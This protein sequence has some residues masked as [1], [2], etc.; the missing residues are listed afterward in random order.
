MSENPGI[1]A[2]VG[3]WRGTSRLYLPERSPSVRQSDSLLNVSLKAKGQFVA[4]DYTWDF[5]GKAQ[6]GL[7]IL[8]CDTRS[9][10]AQAVW[11][12]SWH[13]RNTLMISNGEAS[14]DG[15]VSVMGYYKV[16]GHPDWGWR[17]E[18]TP[19]KD[20]LRLVMYNV[21]P[22]GDEEL[23]VKAEYAKVDDQ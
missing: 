23:A 14:E 9:N 7:I 2:C 8:G 22:E 6:E 1:A 15:S 13:S 18:I 10:A 3:K 12:D 5:E 19:S 16:E 4:F 17:T 11:T 20:N 21:S